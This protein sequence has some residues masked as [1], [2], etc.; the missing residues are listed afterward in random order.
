ME[1]QRINRGSIKK[2]SNLA[3]SKKLV[4]IIIPA[5]NAAK[6]IVETLDSVFAQTYKN[7]EVIVVNDGSKD[8]TLAIIEN[9]LKPITIISTE[10]KGV[11]Q[12]RSLGFAK[13][14]GSFIQ[15]LD[16]DDLLL[17][18]KI[19]RQ[20]SALL[21][22]EADVAYGDWQK[23]KYENDK[24][25]ITEIIE[26]QIEGDLEIALF[27]YFWCPPA[28]LLYSRRLCERLKWNEKLPV[29]Q[30]A[31]YFFDA[32][33]AKGK[34][35]YTSGIMAQYRTAQSNSLSQKSDLNFIKDLFEHTKSVYQLW[36]A[37]ETINSE[38][39]TVIIKSLRHCINRLSVLDKK[40]ARQAINTLLQ[41]KPNYLPTERGLL[42]ELSKIIG[43]KN[44]EK[45]AG[46]KRAIK[47]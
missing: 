43:Y 20:L 27:T 4:S 9:Y 3:S 15:Y 10:N 31:R 42:R 26:R 36:N 21:A 2:D 30:D 8:D 19:E 32:A 11:S 41:I 14:K 46:Y 17:P 6:T 29:I 28:A 47:P 34:F 25:I 45:I 33:I 39:E 40:L 1:T 23:F 44:A 12:A 16:A 5:Y 18:H 37:N 35:V 13:S 24:F 22:H 38:Q 7:L